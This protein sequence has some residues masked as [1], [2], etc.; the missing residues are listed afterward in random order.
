MQRPLFLK[1]KNKV[2]YK[3]FLKENKLFFD[4]GANIGFKTEIFRSIGASVI[5][6]EPQINCCQFLKNKYAQDDSVKIIN[7]GLSSQRGNKK[8]K[9]CSSVSAIS[10]FSNKWEREG[11]FKSYIYDKEE[12]VQM[13]TFDD[14]IEAYG[15]P[16]FAKI[17]VEGYEHEVIS[18]LTL[19]IPCLSFEFTSEFFNDAIKIIDYLI[20]LGFSNFNYNKGEEMKLEIAEWLS[21]DDFIYYMVDEIKV[22]KDLWGD[23]YAK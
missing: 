2:F 19:K 6:V 12:I 14:L 5:A 21:R 8:I 18:G 9:I 1:K 16:D 3:Q 15:V 13:I 4:I 17:D 22:N 11:R 7:K 23:I 20:G 10:T